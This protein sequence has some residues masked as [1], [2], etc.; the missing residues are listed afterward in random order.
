[1][2]PAAGIDISD[3]SIKWMVLERFGSAHR[4]QSYGD[5]ALDEGVVRGGVIQDEKRLAEKLAGIRHHLGGISSVHAALPEEVAYVFS[6]RVPPD[7][8]RQQVL[9]LIEFEFEDRVPIPPS[10]AVY[11]FSPIPG[12]ASDS[13]SEEVSVV[14]FPREIAEAYARVCADAGLTLLSLEIEASSV[15]RVVSSHSEDEPITLLVD[16]GRART[17]FAVIKHGAPIFTS[18]VDVGGDLVTNALI[19]KLAMT[20]EET[21]RFKN[22]HG[23]FDA[24]EE[25]AQAREIVSG[26]AAALADEVNRHYRYWDTRRNDRGDR[27]TPVGKVILIGGSAN[28]KGLDEYIASRVHAPTEVG[29]VWQHVVNF[30][31]YIPPIDRRTSLQYATAVGLALRSV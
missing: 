12:V 30:D 21:I 10:A 27:M 31:E 28:L 22:D 23:L 14:V 20:P 7:T 25:Y 26:V 24:S 9:R 11:D 8:P 1:M 5:S 6:M 19:Q 13:E 16:F 17:G 18:T 3:S 15:A 2:P 4:V 29:D